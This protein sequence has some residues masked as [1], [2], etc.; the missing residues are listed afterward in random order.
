[1]AEVSAAHV[2]WRR[3]MACAVGALV[4]PAWYYGMVYL[5]IQRGRSVAR[6]LI[7][8]TQAIPALAEINRNTRI[9]ETSVNRLWFRSFGGE[10]AISFTLAAL[11]CW[12]LYRRRASAAGSLTS[13]VLIDVAL[14]LAFLA[15]PWLVSAV[16]CL[17]LPEGSPIHFWVFG[18]ALLNALPC[19]AAVA[20]ATAFSIVLPRQ[21]LPGAVA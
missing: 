15:A 19:L 2:P 10:I 17:R 21:E 1:M 4:I 13:R 14:V 12:V 16:T 18:N 5:D 20:G 3:L 7:K 11:T 6:D 9:Y 8:T